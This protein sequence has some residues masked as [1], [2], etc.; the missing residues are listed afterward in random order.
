MSRA[1][2]LRLLLLM[3]AG[4]A[5]FL[6]T[7][8]VGRDA[9]HSVDL[10]PGAAPFD[11]QALAAKARTGDKSAQLELGQRFETGDGVARNLVLAEKLYRSAASDDDGRTQVYLPPVSRSDAGRVITLD[12]G[13]KTP[14]L[15][16]AKE[17]L[18]A[19]RSAS[20][21]QMDDRKGR[22]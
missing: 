1:N 4:C 7:A 8:C 14:G 13:V 21:G 5:G 16:Q 15:R 22:K 20:A 12:F 9:Y 3:G 11:I 6:V 19:L 10:R 18:A 2:K 17:R